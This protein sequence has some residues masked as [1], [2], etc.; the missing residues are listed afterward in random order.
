MHDQEK[1]T[2]AILYA[3][4]NGE[5]KSNRVVEQM[6]KIDDDCDKYGIQF[7]KI[8]DTKANK[9]YGIDKVRQFLP[10]YDLKISMFNNVKFNFKSSLLNVTITEV[11]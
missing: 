10:I 1:L 8:D 7:V 4:N 5:E 3:D 11:C 2:C 6:E 9:E